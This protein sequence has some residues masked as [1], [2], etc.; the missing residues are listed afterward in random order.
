MN[1]QPR[2]VWLDLETTGLNPAEGIILEYGIIITD[3]EL[4]E[5]TRKSWVLPWSRASLLENLKDDYVLNMH[6]TNG[7]FQESHKAYDGLIVDP[8]ILMSRNATACDMREDITQ[9]VLVF[10][11]A[12]LPVEGSARTT[13][14]AGSSIHFDRL[15]QGEKNPDLLKKVSHRMG[16]VSA[17]LVFF[18]E[19]FPK[20]PNAKPTAHRALDDLEASIE[21]HRT[22]RNVVAAGIEALKAKLVKS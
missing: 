13:F 6:T 21:M 2:L 10:L 4:R 3:L 18:P 5:I 15:W 20:K 12:N 17:N 19:L 8:A 14:L 7:L 22:M 1:N 9:D 11:E 16:D